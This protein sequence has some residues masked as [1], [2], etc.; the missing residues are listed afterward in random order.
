MDILSIFN[1]TDYRKY[2]SDWFQ[3]KKEHNPHFS[4]RILASK[5]GYRSSG[6]FSQIIKG[7]SNLSAKSIPR[8]IQYLKLNNREAEYFELMIQFNHSKIDEE[9]SRCFQRMA[10]FK[11]AKHRVLDQNFYEFYDKWYYA[12]IRDILAYFPFK[13][14]YQALS[15]LLEPSI[16]IA[17]AKRSIKLLE[18][19]KLIEKSKSGFYDRTDKVLRT[20]TDKLN[21]ALV[22]YTHK[23]M[24][25][26]K[27]ASLRIPRDERSMSCV[28]FV[29]SENT[30]KRIKSEVDE[31]Q[32]RIL[33]I[34]E[35]DQNP[36]RVYH[37]NMQIFPVSKKLKDGNR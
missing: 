14:D 36:E 7:Q 18:K 34:A 9:K 8:F 32:L 35:E 31:F 25:K 16:S 3:I 6:H 37:M 30:Y 15:E 21:V 19:L 20:K 23:M 12:V 22:N 26:A 11:E 28:G 17:E 33:K 4:C 1:Y 27:T 29:V 13:D 5:V 2:L 10:Q 24:D